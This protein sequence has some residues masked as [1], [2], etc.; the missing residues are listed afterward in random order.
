MISQPVALGSP[1]ASFVLLRGRLLQWSTGWETPSS[2]WIATDPEVTRVSRAI[3]VGG[4]R[5]DTM[6]SAERMDAVMAGRKPDRVPFNLFGAG[7]SARN[8]GYPTEVAYTDPQ[9]CMEAQLWTGEQFGCEPTTGTG[10][11]SYGAYEFGG[12]IRMPRSQWE[13]A[14]SIVRPAVESEEELEKLGLPDVKTAGMI[15]HFMEFSKLQ[16]RLGL[17]ISCG[18]SGDPATNAA[19]MVGVNRFCRWMVKRPELAHRALRL[20]TDHII[21]AWDYWS[22]TFGAERV[23][24]GVYVTLA[25][26][27]IM[28]P[29]QFERFVMPYQAELHDRIRDT[30]IEGAMFHICG[31]QNLNLPM[32]RGLYLGSP[33]RPFT[34]S[35]GHEVDL[36]T[37]IA[38]FPD[39]IICGNV[40]PQII[41]NGTPQQV[42]EV[43]RVAIEKG[44]KAP[45]GHILMPGCD[46]PPMAP[47]YNVWTMRKAV[48]DFGFFD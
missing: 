26:N 24:V 39:N 28:G 41:Q 32:I 35:F 46:L 6:G 31:Q 17:P 45:R 19:N 44:K 7:F 9:K 13:S 23:S 14:P 33:Q 40:E 47:G 20:A 21:Q 3:C 27:Q 25:A 36:D 1:S 30:G 34:L 37:A 42:Y 15:P 10:Y 22:E 4:L 48:S 18:I 5:P 38:M 16:E 11:A 43:T 2:S 12:E 29:R 8:V